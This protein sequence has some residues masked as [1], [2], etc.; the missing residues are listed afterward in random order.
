MYEFKNPNPE[1][2]L[3]KV[4]VV[5]ERNSQ[6]RVGSRNNPRWK[7]GVGGGESLKLLLDQPSSPYLNFTRGYT[8]EK[9]KTA[10]VVVITVLS[11]KECWCPK[12]DP[13]GGGRGEIAQH[14]RQRALLTPCHEFVLSGQNIFKNYENVYMNSTL[15]FPRAKYVFSVMSILHYL[16][17]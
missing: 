17:F 11:L 10:A 2:V 4:R 7:G 13:W 6:W 12:S 9:H 1:K 16:K 8:H 5:L 14:W 15:S 3:L